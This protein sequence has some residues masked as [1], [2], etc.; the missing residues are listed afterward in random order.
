MNVFFMQVAEEQ[1][2]V[3]GVDSK[4]PYSYAQLIIQVCDAVVFSM[5]FVILLI[6]HT[7]MVKTYRSATSD[8]VNDMFC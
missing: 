2:S 6:N 5:D 3:E 8:A 7:A 1:S 4:P